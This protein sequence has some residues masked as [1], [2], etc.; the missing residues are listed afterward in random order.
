MSRLI[1]EILAITDS[2]ICSLSVSYLK[3]KGARA[4]VY[5]PKAI[6]CCLVWIRN[7]VSHADS[8]A[9]LN[10]ECLKKMPR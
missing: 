2:R 6:T 8:G 10:W 4:R 5:R 3:P 1:L 9:Y 7:M